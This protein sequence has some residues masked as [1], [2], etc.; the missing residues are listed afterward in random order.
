MAGFFFAVNFSNEHLYNHLKTFMTEGRAELFDKVLDQRTRYVAVLL[1]NIFQPH[2]ASAVLRSCDCFGIQD[3]H[4]TEEGAQYEV[5]KGVSL[6]ASQWLTLHRHGDAEGSLL[7]CL[8]QLR[9]NGYAIVATT[10]GDE[11]MSIS[12]I[13][14][15]KPVAIAFGTELSGLSEQAIENSDYTAHIPMYGFTESFNISVAAAI[16]LKVL[17]ERIREEKVN[18]QLS[19]EE[20]LALKVEWA[21]NTIKSSDLIVE[22]YLS[23]RD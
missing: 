20:R 7:K 10:P 14:L 8:D 6:G 15:D 5:N 4:V 13:P 12:E 2:N 19:E 1:E 11:S 22:R 17:S 9:N 18:W 23:E 16:S 21:K 3:V